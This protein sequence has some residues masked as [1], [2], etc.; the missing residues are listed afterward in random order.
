MHWRYEWIAALPQDV[1]DVLLEL[2]KEWMKVGETT[3]EFEGLL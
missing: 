2:A 3:D 1:Y